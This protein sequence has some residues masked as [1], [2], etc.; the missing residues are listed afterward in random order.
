M[1]HILPLVESLEIWKRSQ[2]SEVQTCRTGSATQSSS[3]LETLIW[4]DQL[5]RRTAVAGGT[6]KVS[7]SPA[8][9][10]HVLIWKIGN[11]LWHT[12]SSFNQYR[13]KY[14]LLLAHRIPKEGGNT[15]YADVRTAFRDLPEER[16]AQLRGLVV[17]HEYGC[18]YLLSDMLS[19]VIVSLAA[20]GTLALWL[21]PKSSRVSRSMR[22]LRNNQHIT[23]SYR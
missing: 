11:A 6:I 9:F 3:T 8:W 23:S 20:C 14:S 21:L 17:K 7:L 10:M 1:K 2:S 5:S 4:T 13:S 16:K 19:K 22:K 15:E 12:D 18:L